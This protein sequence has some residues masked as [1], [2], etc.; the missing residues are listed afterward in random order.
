[1]RSCLRGVLIHTVNTI[2]EP[3]QLPPLK[4]RVEEALR[5]S[6]LKRSTLYRLMRAG[7]IK[8]CLFHT[9]KKKQNTLR[10]VDYA[11][12]KKFLNGLPEELG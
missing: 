4:I 11:S 3:Q 7:K 10:L 5:I 2:L 8:S 12:L 1:V 9:T 6:G